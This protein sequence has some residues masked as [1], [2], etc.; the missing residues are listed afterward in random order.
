MDFGNYIFEQ[1]VKHAKMD[2][3]NIPIAFP[4]L[5]C[6]IILDQHLII[7]NVVD[8]PKKRESPLTL[9]Y[10]LF[11]ANHVLDIVGTFETVRSTGLMT[12]KEI[13]DALKDTCKILDERKAQ[14]ELVIQALEHEDGAAESEHTRNK[15]EKD[16][17]NKD[18]EEASDSSSNVA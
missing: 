4:T 12:R 18:E 10:K 8:V 13:V 7:K 17:A 16:D 2:A 11:G 5:S 15:D 9:H 14:F 6:S 1:T 3:V